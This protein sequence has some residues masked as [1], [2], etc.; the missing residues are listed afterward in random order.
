MQKIVDKYVLE[1]PIGKGQFG[2]VYKG[3][4]C[5]SKEDVAVKSISRKKIKG[6]LFDLLNN[7]IEVLQNC[8]NNNIVKLF[9]IRIT[10][11]NYYL[12]MEYCNEGDLEGLL[13]E[14]K[15]LLIWRLTK[16]TIRRRGS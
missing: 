9:D 8:N 12:V 3:Y 11:N 5:V 2:L 16:E 7:E 4:H 14:R 10:A 1:R 13:R 6:K 15:V